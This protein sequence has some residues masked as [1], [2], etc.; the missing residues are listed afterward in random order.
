M[1]DDVRIGV[2]GIKPVSF[3]GRTGGMVF[4]PEDVAQA[5]LE[6]KEADNGDSI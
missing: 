4:M 5:A 6:A 3:F 2:N 1:V